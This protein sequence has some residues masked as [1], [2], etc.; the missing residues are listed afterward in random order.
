MIP[1]NY[2][3]TLI[4]LIKAQNCSPRINKES[5]LLSKRG[6]KIFISCCFST[7]QINMKNWENSLLSSTTFGLTDTGWGEQ[8]LT[9][10]WFR[11]TTLSRQKTPISDKN[12]CP[13]EEEFQRTARYKILHFRKNHQFVCP[14]SLLCLSSFTSLFDHT[15]QTHT[16]LCW[17]RLSCRLKYLPQISHE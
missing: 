2:Y 9:V 6:R 16:Y 1:W 5:G 8:D 7:Q 14:C 4:S 15:T 13:K 17:R 3:R 12:V 11:S 10:R